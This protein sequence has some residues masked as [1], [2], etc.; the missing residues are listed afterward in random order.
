MAGLAEAV[1][2]ADRCL[3]LDGAM[4]TQLHEAG[5]PPG[6]APELWNVME[7][8]KVMAVHRAYLAAGVEMI[9]TNTFGANPV[10]LAS[11]G[12]AER[13][14]ELNRAGVELARQAAAGGAWVIGSMGP[15]GRLLAPLGDLSAAEAA[16]GFAR[17]ARALAAAGVDAINIETMADLAEMRLAIAAALAAGLPVMAEAVFA[18]NGRTM[19]GAPPE[20]VGVFFS[21]FP[22]LAAGTNCGLTPEELAPL[23]PRLRS[24]WTG[25]LLVQANAGRPGSY[26][27]AE[28]FAA[29]TV[30]LAEMGAAIIGGCCGT[31]P[32]HIA[33]L[34]DKLRHKKAAQRPGAKPGMIASRDRVA[35]APELSACPRVAVRDG[36]EDLFTAAQDLGEVEVIAFDLTGYAGDPGEIGRSL[37][38][39]WPTVSQP[40]IL[41]AD[42][43]EV[44]AAAIGSYPGRPGASG[45]SAL[46]GTAQELG[47]LWIEP[48]KS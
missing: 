1:R 27:G 7:P 22:L 23:L 17:Q 46:A 16:A 21:G 29:A 8:A 35:V 30:R 38:L 14:E 45:P 47:A 39:F 12:L 5:L 3:I 11:F 34:R 9:E 41:I 13:T 19:F 42:H 2:G 40:A 44:L 33:S 6:T 36:E 31:G 4:G 32:E 28:E 18:E 15:C 48:G 37:A 25:P 26:L 20:V 10:K 24:G 43:R